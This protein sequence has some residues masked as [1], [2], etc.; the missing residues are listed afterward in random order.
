M[1][2]SVGD[3]LID[4]IGTACVVLVFAYVLTRTKLFTEVL[5]KQ[6]NL[7]NRAILILLFGAMSIYGTYGGIRLSSG[8]IANIR[9]LSPMVGG[10]VGGPVIG[11]GAGLM[12]GIHRYF[13]GGLTHV[14]CSLATVIAGL[15]GGVIYKL[16]K[17]EFPAV[18]QATLFAIVMEFLHMG[19]TL[20]IVRPY[21][22]AWAT[23]K[24]VTLPMTTANAIGMAI[25]AWIVHN[26]IVERKTA[27][28]KKQVTSLF[29]KYVSPQAAAAIIELADRD[30]LALGGE[31]REVTVLFADARGFT[32]LCDKVKPDKLVDALNTYFSAIIE[33]INANEGMVNKFAG[34]N[35]M[36]VWNAP[37][38]QPDHAFLAVKTAIESQIAIQEINQRLV[39]F[40][41]TQFGI[42]INTGNAIAGSVGSKQRA[43]YTVIGDAVNLASRI[44]GA[45]PGGRVWIGGQTFDKVKE[46]VTVSELG[47]QHFKGKEEAFAVYQVNS[48]R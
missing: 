4:L 34:D 27:A 9:D 13:L 21:D 41:A 6:F 29:G 17:G 16:R 10:L 18:W 48:I 33:H 26:L 32:Q 30:E 12:G 2:V 42:G 24:N 47:P 3:M 45:A 20:L 7:K 38:S 19:L 39:D 14:P 40:P 5:D 15:M 37:Q 25:F 43:E 23:V 31:N 8:A 1:K 11:L 46:R 35:I 28:E 36:A 22:E 44:C